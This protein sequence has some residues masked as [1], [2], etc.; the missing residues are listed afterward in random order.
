[1]FKFHGHILKFTQNKIWIFLLP[2]K[3]AS[4]MA[5][6]KTASTTRVNADIKIL[7]I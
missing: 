7:L 1:M 6:E 4:A 5:E 2:A 3:M